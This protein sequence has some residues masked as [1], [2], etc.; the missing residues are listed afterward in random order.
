MAEVC[1]VLIVIANEKGDQG[2]LKH[3]LQLTNFSRL[4]DL[5]RCLSL[6]RCTFCYIPLIPLCSRKKNFMYF[7]TVSM[8]SVTYSV[9]LL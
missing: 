3:I 4:E 6:G 2:I 5:D 7:F 9:T 8:E 1:I